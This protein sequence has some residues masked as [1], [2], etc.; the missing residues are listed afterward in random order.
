MYNIYMADCSLST[1][2][3]RAYTNLLNMTVIMTYRNWPLLTG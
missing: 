3:A 1:P 2:G